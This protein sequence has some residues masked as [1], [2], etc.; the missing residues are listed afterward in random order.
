MSKNRM[1]ALRLHNINTGSLKW[2]QSVSPENSIADVPESKI[3]NLFIK[4]PASAKAEKWAFKAI[5][6]MDGGYGAITCFSP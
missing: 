5:H 1:T 3:N 6:L 2:A 4:S